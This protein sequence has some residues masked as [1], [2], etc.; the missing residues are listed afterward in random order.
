MGRPRKRRHGDTAHSQTLDPWSLGSVNRE[1]ETNPY[2]REPN[3]NLSVSNA[4]GTVS[5]GDASFSTSNLDIPSMAMHEGPLYGQI[6]GPDYQATGFDFTFSQSQSS[7]PLVNFPEIASPNVFQSLAPEANDTQLQTSLSALDPGDYSGAETQSARCSC[8]PQLY[9]FLGAFQAPPDP[10]FPYSLVAL[11]KA[12]RFAKEAVHCQHCATEYTSAVQNAMLLGTLMTLVINEYRKL[13]DHIDEQATN[14]ET[15]IMRVGNMSLENAHMHTGT[16]D[17]PM[18]I[19]LEVSG[20]EW[21]LFAR[22]TLRKEV[23]GPGDYNVAQI[24][25]EM[26]DRQQRWHACHTKCPPRNSPRFGA[27]H[28]E[29][30]GSDTNVCIQGMYIERL[31]QSLDALGI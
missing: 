18:G 20:H 16:R 1:E 29:E 13:L 5:E 27:E 4:L 2:D 22:R 14:D 21:K 31:V 24:L 23:V 25:Q 12:T 8:L 30:T 28:L 10:I 17:C 26:K 3:E 7:N 11:K 15:K 9:T 6:H 19:N